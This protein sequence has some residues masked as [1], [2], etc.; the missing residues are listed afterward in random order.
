M[1]ALESAN[2]LFAKARRRGAHIVV[3]GS[4]RSPLDDRSTIV[5][6]RAV[7]AQCERDLLTHE[8]KPRP[9]GSPSRRESANPRLR[10]A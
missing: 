6:P 2:A 8:Q 7:I 10:P 4:V 1:G 3:P 5:V 9:E